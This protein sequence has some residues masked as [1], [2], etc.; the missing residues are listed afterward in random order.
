MANDPFT[1]GTAGQGLLNAELYNGLAA[2]DAVIASH[3]R[4]AIYAGSGKSSAEAKKRID[5]LEAERVNYIRK[6][7]AS[8]AGFDELLRLLKEEQAN[9]AKV[10][11]EL[12]LRDS[13]L[14]EWMHQNQALRLL[15]KQ[16][17]EK[18]GVSLE[19]RRED[20]DNKLLDVAE[21]D[22]SFAN[23]ELTANAKLAKS[24]K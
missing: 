9:R 18:A 14:A 5:E 2:K 1:T 16:Y 22:P 21:E 12:V 3:Q 7:Q 17:G 8:E 23:T 19:Q 13:I 15:V 11:Q 4:A 24:Q 10:E 6:L 20:Y